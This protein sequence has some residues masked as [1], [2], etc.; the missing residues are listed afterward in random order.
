MMQTSHR[1]RHILPFMMYVLMH[2]VIALTSQN[3]VLMSTMKINFSEKLGI[4]VT[5]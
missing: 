2:V 1:V 4:V 3:P 5:M